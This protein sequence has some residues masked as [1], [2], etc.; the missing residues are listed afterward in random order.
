MASLLYLYTS[1]LA[2]RVAVLIL[3]RSLAPAFYTSHLVI[4]VYYSRRGHVHESCAILVGLRPHL[5]NFSLPVVEHM[6]AWEQ[7]G[8][9]HPSR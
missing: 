2:K 7:M 8:T 6:V 3:R 5:L 9:H 1:K 4:G